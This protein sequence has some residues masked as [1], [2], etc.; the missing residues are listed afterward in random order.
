MAY[1]NP[2]ELKSTWVGNKGIYRTRMIVADGGEL[3]LLAPGLAAFGENPE[4]DEMIRCYGYTDTETIMKLYHKGAF[5]GRSMCAAHLLPRR[6]RRALYHHLC[7]EAR[8]GFP[9]GSGERGLSV[10][11]LP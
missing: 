1:L 2:E 4:A 7:H 6:Y 5:E 10:G 8:E 3:L 9:A 11:R